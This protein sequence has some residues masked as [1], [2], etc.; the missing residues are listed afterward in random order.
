MALVKMLRDIP[1]V[2]GGKTEAMIPEDAVAQAM[3][4]GWRKADVKNEKSES[5]PASKAESKPE[6]KV[7]EPEVEPVKEEP[8]APKF[9]KTSEKKGKK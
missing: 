2:A 8:E 5:K 7:E 1:E 4:N 3:N 9:E 6:P